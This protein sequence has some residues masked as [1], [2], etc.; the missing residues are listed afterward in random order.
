M[1]NNTIVPSAQSCNDTAM[2]IALA[3]TITR[4]VAKVIGALTTTIAMN[5]SPRIGT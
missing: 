1:S 5:M 2:T 3:H 4:I